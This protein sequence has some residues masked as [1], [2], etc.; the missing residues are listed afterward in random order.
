MAKP[1]RRIDRWICEE[2][3]G[4][5]TIAIRYDLNN[6]TTEHLQLAVPSRCIFGRTD[7]HR[8]YAAAWKRVKPKAKTRRRKKEGGER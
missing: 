2:C 4:S 6:H 3:D 8:Y 1:Q 5:C 7:E